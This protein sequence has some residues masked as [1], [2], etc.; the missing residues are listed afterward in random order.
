M[1]NSS[2]DTHQRKVF[3]SVGE[4]SSTINDNHSIASLI[5]LKIIGPLPDL[6]LKLYPEFL[7]ES[8]PISRANMNILFTNS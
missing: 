5:N 2:A 1:A 8:L 7:I 3:G 4:Q 6:K